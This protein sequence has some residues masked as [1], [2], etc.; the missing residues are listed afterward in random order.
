VPPNPPLAQAIAAYG[1]S[2]RLNQRPAD[3]LLLAHE[4]LCRELWAAKGAYEQNRLDQMCRHTAR[5]TQ[6]LFS[7]RAALDVGASGADRTRLATFYNGLL[8]NIIGLLNRP[9][10]SE[11]LQASIGRLRELCT[12][13][14]IATS[15]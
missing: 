10:V 11:S 1:A 9:S 13:F 14:Q 2:Q 3:V 15:R 6:I 12:E 7:L 4:T 5:C 8:S